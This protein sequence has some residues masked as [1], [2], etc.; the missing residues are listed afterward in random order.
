MVAV[1][2]LLAVPQMSES[3]RDVRSHWFEKPRATLKWWDESVDFVVFRAGVRPRNGV[4]ER[5]DLERPGEVKSD[6]KV[7]RF[8]ID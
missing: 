3:W 8:N 5:T 1:E 2:R 4:L 6:A 7:D